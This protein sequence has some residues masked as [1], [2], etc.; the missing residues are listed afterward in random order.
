ME[1]LVFRTNLM[2][3]KKIGDVQGHLDEHPLIEQWNVDLHDH[4]KILRIVSTGLPGKDV[5]AMIESAGYVC[6]ELS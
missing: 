3:R 6:K 5:E 2:N 1:I 4:D